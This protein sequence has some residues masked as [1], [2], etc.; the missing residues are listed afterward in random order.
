[1]ITKDD[2]KLK[3]NTRILRKN[4]TLPEILFW[5][6]VKNKRIGYKFTR[7]KIIDSFIVDFYCPKK[8]LIIEID[9]RDHDYKVDYDEYREARLVSLG[10]KVLRF[11]NHQIYNNLNG[12]VDYLKRYLAGDPDCDS[13]RPW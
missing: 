12:C 1:M 9:G 11:S 10:Y 5:G 2:K 6:E 8:K 3:D 7:Q 4:S 13:L